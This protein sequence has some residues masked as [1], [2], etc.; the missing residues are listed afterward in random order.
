MDDNIGRLLDYLEKEGLLENTLIVYTSDQGFYMG[1]HGWFD[2]RF[3]Y[4]ECH[5]MPLLVRYPKLIKAGSSSSAM[6]MNVDFAPTFLD[7]AG[8]KIPSDIQGKSLVPILAGNGT[9]PNNWRDAVYYHYYEYPAEH[10]VKRHYGIR[11][12]EYKLIHFYEDI[13]E[14]ELYDLKRDPFEMNNVWNDA[15]YATVKQEMTAKLKNL[16]SSYNDTS[17]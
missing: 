9:E 1:E 2:K 15:T 10:S 14:W 13:N 6:C 16:Q 3:M 11:T 4:E 8:V 12:K 5:R 17:M 7:L